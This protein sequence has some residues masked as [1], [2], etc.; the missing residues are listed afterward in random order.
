MIKSSSSVR[1]LQRGDTQKLEVSF[2]EDEAKTIP[3]VSFN[4]DD[5]PSYTI[6][7]VSNTDVSNGVGTY[8]SPGNWRATWAIPENAALSSDDRKY[9]IEWYLLD[10]NRR[11]F[12]FVQEFD[13]VDTIINESE[14]AEQQLQTL[15]NKPFVFI[16]KTKVI[17][18]DIELTVFPGTSETN[19]VIENISLQGG[20][21]LMRND[22]IWQVYYYDPEEVVLTNP[23]MYTALWAVKETENSTPNYDYQLINV[24]PASILQFIPPVRMVIDKIQ[25]KINTIEGYQ[26]SDIVQY[27]MRGL[28]FINGWFPVTYF[29]VNSIPKPLHVAWI[30]ASSWYGLNAQHLLE[31]ELTYEFSGQ[32]DSFSFDH[33]AG[34]ESVLSRIWEYMTNELT[35]TKTQIFR[36]SHRVGVGANRMQTLKGGYG[37]GLVFPVGR[38]GAMGGGDIASGNFVAFFGL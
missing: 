28:E 32:V 3:I 17:P 15:V 20:D 24:I 35:K 26:D 4:I 25:K 22:D 38:G 33:A 31:V 5:Y 18:Y 16:Y 13:V 1:S 10:V 21:I 30:M 29:T 34:I 7:D 36:T 12:N 23:C 27:L 6:Y 11:Q 2:F 14:I 8:T 19:P 9:R 37:Q